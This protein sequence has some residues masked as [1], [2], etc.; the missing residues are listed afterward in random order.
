M[1]ALW[2][3]LPCSRVFLRILYLGIG[4]SMFMAYFYLR[5]KLEHTDPTIIITSF[6]SDSIMRKAIVLKKGQ[7]GEIAASTSGIRPLT[8]VQR[9]S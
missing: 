7:L 9:G 5:Y 3:S 2:V 4:K 6:D 1:P 8:R